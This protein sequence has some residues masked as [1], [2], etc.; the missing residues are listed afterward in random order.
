MGATLDIFVQA[1]LGLAILA[2]VGVGLAWLGL[3]F[4]AFVRS[5]RRVA[6]I[7]LELEREA[8]GGEP[9]RARVRAL[10]APRTLGPLLSTLSGEAPP[11]LGP[12]APALLWAGGAMALPAVGLALAAL[13]SP[14]P[15]TFLAAGLGLGLVL[16]LSLL[17]V[18]GVHLVERS[19]HRTIRQA[20]LIL[21][22]TNARAEIDR[23]S[24]AGRRA[25]SDEVEAG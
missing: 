9:Q 17:A 18:R 16:P 25:P 20:C 1:P 12:Q 2:W 13:L 3:C 15:R 14:D 8:L 23:S 5:R 22:E 11:D 10:E 4:L 6:R 24:S 7:A 21:L 19:A